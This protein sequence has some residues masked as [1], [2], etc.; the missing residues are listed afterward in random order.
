MLEICPAI[1]IHF[2][3]DSEVAV[4]SVQYTG[5]EQKK[6]KLAPESQG[7]ATTKGLALPVCAAIEIL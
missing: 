5:N 2:L 3:A 4:M 7:W 6:R 1:E